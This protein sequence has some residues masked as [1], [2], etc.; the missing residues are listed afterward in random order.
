MDKRIAGIV[1]CLW[2][3]ACTGGSGSSDTVERSGVAVF[4]DSTCAT[5]SDAVGWPEVLKS[6]I[7][8][9][10]WYD[11]RIGERLDNYNIEKT[12][13]DNPSIHHYKYGVISLGLNDIGQGEYLGHVLDRYESDLAIIASYGLEPVCLTYPYTTIIS[14]RLNDFNEGIKIICASYKIITSTE[15]LTDGIHPANA[16]SMETAEDAWRVLY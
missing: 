7:P 13:K 8:E 11:A 6:L 3:S 15:Q 5:V 14:D 9:T 1:L 10:V 12:L 4:C 16:G 2:L